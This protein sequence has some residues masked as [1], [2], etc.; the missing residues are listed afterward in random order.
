LVMGQGKYRCQMEAIGRHY[1]L[2]GAKPL[3]SHFLKQEWGHLFFGL[4]YSKPG[5][6]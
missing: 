3:G 5:C 6:Y 1:T 4:T 2:I